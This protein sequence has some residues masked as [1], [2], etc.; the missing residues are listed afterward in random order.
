MYNHVVLAAGHGGSDPG[1]VHG[2][3]HE[4]RDVIIQ[5]NMAAEILIKNGIKVSVVPH[6]LN[7]HAQIEWINARYT[8]PNV[9]ALEIH[10][11]SSVM[12]ARGIEVFAYPGLNQR[13][14]EAKKLSRL[15]SE[16]S[17]VIN[18]GGK[19]RNFAWIREVEAPA[20]LVENGF[21]Q[22]GPTDRDGIV[23]YEKMLGSAL[24]YA[25]MDFLGKGV[26]MPAPEPP[27]VDSNI[28]LRVWKP[29]MSA[30]T[31]ELTEENFALGNAMFFSTGEIAYQYDG[32]IGFLQITPYGEIVSVP[33]RLG[34]G[35]LSGGSKPGLIQI[36]KDDF[37][38]YGYG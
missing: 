14:N 18:R 5:V 15:L 10:K 25:I 31:E 37:K 2:T 9:L 12:Q 11:N 23:K 36:T 19:S 6:T 4:A 24:A 8:T 3:E 38:V 21:I 26:I 17:G 16:K 1:A 30:V 22:S 13:L 32:F 34:G 33:Y 7:L 29:D 27:A 35:V 28:V 20:L